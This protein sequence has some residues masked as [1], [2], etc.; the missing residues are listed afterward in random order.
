MNEPAKRRSALS[1]RLRLSLWFLAV[2]TILHAV[3]L[4]ALVAL[5]GS[6]VRRSNE[7]RVET[8]AR[9]MIDN[10][11]LATPTWTI[12]EIVPLV[13]FDANFAFWVLRDPGTDVLLAWEADPDSVPF[14]PNES[15][16]AGPRGAVF[17]RVTGELARDLLPDEDTVE[18]L[19]LPFRDT[20]GEYFL[21]VG[22]RTEEL[23]GILR[24]FL[25]LFVIG[26]PLASFAALAA[27]W[28]ISGQAVKPLLNLS[29]AARDVTPSRLGARFLLG[30]QGEEVSTVQD[31]LNQAMERLEVGFRSQDE[32]IS[33]VS[34]EL[35]T[36]I[37]ILRSQS[38]LLR[39]GEHENDAYRE[40]VDSVEEETKRLGRMVESFLS[41]ARH[42][43]TKRLTEKVELDAIDLVVDAVRHATPLA[44]LNGVHLSPVIRLDDPDADPPV[45]EG[46]PA[47]LET[48]LENLM[49]NAIRF[50][51]K[52]ATVHLEAHQEGSEVV[53]RVRDEGPGVPDGMLEQ[54]FE[55]YV[56]WE[57]P[58][59][60]RGAG[61]G[62]TIARN[63][64]ELYGGTIGA[65]NAEEGGAVFTVRLPV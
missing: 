41:L 2:F 26:I 13:P 62:L 1:L 49:R 37:A 20:T 34:H 3:G 17:S 33:N 43:W 7:N 63:V 8:Q 27:A 30:T 51:P 18:L 39:Q 55:R 40:F 52:N 19:T 5:R 29:R 21:Q 36:P 65:H 24:P 28:M 23:E 38:Q 6:L 9:A 48:M 22:V 64:A 14:T 11:V 58:R 12:E 32:F 45:L 61:I 31:E 16:P 42:G 15:V 56:G 53:F 59:G 25:D 4:Y 46:D 47:L 44:E 10:I 35:K 50:S 54:I 60:T 57:D